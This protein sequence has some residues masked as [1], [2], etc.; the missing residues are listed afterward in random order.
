MRRTAF[1]R[2]RARSLA[3]A[4]RCGF[5][6]CRGEWWCAAGRAQRRWPERAH[7]AAATSA[8]PWLGRCRPSCRSSP[9][10]R[11]GRAVVVNLVG[12]AEIIAVIAHGEDFIRAAAINHAASS[13]LMRKKRAGFIE[14]ILMY[15]GMLSL[16]SNRAGSGEFAAANLV[17]A[18][19]SSA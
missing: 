10:C 3:R 2:R 12:D 13:V 4:V 6:R 19:R 1:F 8:C 7:A 17:E 16:R 5:P 9:R 18:S 11:R 14:M 15:S